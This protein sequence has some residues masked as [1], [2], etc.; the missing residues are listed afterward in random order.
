MNKQIS[1][2]RFL[3]ALSI[4]FFLIMILILLVTVFAG[5]A[6]VPPASQISPL[7]SPT[8]VIS[9]SPT[10]VVNKTFT[11]PYFWKVIYPQD[12]KVATKIATDSASVA[13]FSLSFLD[14]KQP[15]DKNSFYGY[16]VEFRVDNLKGTLATFADKDSLQQTIGDR[17]SFAQVTLSGKKGYRAAL[18]TAQDYFEY[19]LPLKDTTKVLTVTTSVNGPT[20]ETY[21]PIVTQIVNSIELLD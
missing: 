5:Q 14:T 11:S 3:W 12:A 10:P 17:V 20:A 6:K 7:V 1:S 13:R 4:F 19:Y 18:K 15:A 8:P 16:L 2:T 9:S 21:Q